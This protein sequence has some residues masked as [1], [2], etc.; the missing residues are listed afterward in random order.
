MKSELTDW[1]KMDAIHR[2]AKPRLVYALQNQLPILGVG[3][4][5]GQ[6]SEGNGEVGVEV[7]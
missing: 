1:Q 6:E 4:S 7:A 2:F 5:P 3:Q